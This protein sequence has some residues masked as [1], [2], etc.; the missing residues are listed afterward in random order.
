MFQ[1][2]RG[3]HYG[4]DF[5]S[6]YTLSRSEMA[7]GC[8]ALG[9]RN[10]DP[11]IEL[12]RQDFQPVEPREVKKRQGQAAMFSRESETLWDQPPVLYMAML[13]MLV[14]VTK[15]VTFMTFYD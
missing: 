5:D 7:W 13:A 6:R 8:D 15:F 12:L 3:Q 4:G 1:R 11:N 14:V 9:R 10:G 2:D